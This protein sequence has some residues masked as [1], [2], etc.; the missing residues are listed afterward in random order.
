MIHT[1]MAHPNLPANKRMVKMWGRYWFRDMTSEEFKL[2]KKECCG[3]IWD[4]CSDEE[5]IEYSLR[6]KAVDN[7]LQPYSSHKLLYFPKVGKDEAC[8]IIDNHHN[9]YDGVSTLKSVHLMSDQV[10]N[11]ED[12]QPLTALA[13][14]FSTL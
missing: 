13:R 9:V 12:H 14:G 3:V 4:Q 8:F 11:G 1:I 10:I 2:W 7:M 6:I 5:V